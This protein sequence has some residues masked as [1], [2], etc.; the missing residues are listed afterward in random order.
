MPIAVQEGDAGVAPWPW[1]RRRRAQ[2]RVPSQPR[3]GRIFA[4]AAEIVLPTG[5]ENEGL[6]R[7]VTVFEPFAAFG[8]MLPADGFVQAQTGFEIPL[9][10]DRTPT[11]SSGGR[12]WARASCRASSD[13]RGR[14][15]SKCSAPRSSTTAN[16]GAL[17]R[18]A[19]DA[20]DAQHAAAHHDQRRRQDSGQ[21]ARPRAAT[22]VLTYFLWDWFDGGLFDGWPSLHGGRSLFLGACLLA[23]WRSLWPAGRGAARAQA[24]PHRPA[25]PVSFQ[26]GAECMACHNG[27]TTPAGEDVSIGV[28]W[29]ASM[30]A[31]SSRDPYWQGAVRREAIDHPEHAAAIEDE[32]SICHMP[33]TTYPARAAGGLGQ[34][35]AHLPIG[36][37]RLRI[38]WP[39]TACPARSA[40]RSRE[41]RLGSPE[42]FTGGYVLNVAEPGR[43]QPMFGPFDVDEGRTHVMRSATGLTPTEVDPRP[44]VGAVRHVPHAVH[45]GARR[46]GPAGRQ[47]SGAG[48]VSGV[49]A[50]RLPRRTE[51]PGLPHARRWPSRRRLPR[52]SASRARA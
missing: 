43:P 38:R 18:R 44:A 41:E 31:H 12:S 52:S 2:A 35:F 4:A 42:S 39:P 10:E 45:A 50:Q 27:L 17:G 48:A 16:H 49:A 34:V 9:A 46:R 29:R 28:S 22:Q 5:K 30:M 24:D 40:T 14:R 1:R 33:M 36:S 13:A 7:G 32:C 11:S 6:G 47:A 23:S 8:Q 20:G 15:W 37:P 3:A 26:T 25:G 51:L 19:A 21:R